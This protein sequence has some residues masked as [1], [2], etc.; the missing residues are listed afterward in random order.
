MLQATI[1]EACCSLFVNRAKTY[2]LQ[3]VFP[4]QLVVPEPPSAK[5]AV[6]TTK[7]PRNIRVAATTSRV[8]FTVVFSLFGE[9]NRDIF[10]AAR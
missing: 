10:R 1:A 7:V 6:G 5:E 9:L 3:S 4:P 8:R 2:G